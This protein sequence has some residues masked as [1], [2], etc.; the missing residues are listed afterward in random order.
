[1]GGSLAQEHRIP[2]EIL[3]LF[4]FFIIFE[5]DVSEDEFLKNPDD[6]ELQQGVYAPRQSVSAKNSFQINADKISYDEIIHKELKVMDLSACS[7]C[8]E[9]KMPIVVFDFALK[10]SILKVLQGD[11]VGTIVGE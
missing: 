2:I 7:L 3:D 8:K 10:D 5:A 1:M 6:T 9:N 4:V 11:D